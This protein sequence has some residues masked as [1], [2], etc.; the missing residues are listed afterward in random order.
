MKNT[1][2]LLSL[3]LVSGVGFA[4]SR[5]NSPKMTI[6]P[7]PISTLDENVT[8][9]S[10]S[11]D[12]KWIP[13]EYRIYQRIL[14][15]QME[16]LE[17]DPQQLGID[18]FETISTY[19]LY[20]GDDTLLLI[21]K[22]FLDGE[23]D[24]PRSKRGWDDWWSVHYFVIDKPADHH[25]DLNDSSLHEV[26]Y[27]LRASGTIQDVSRRKILQKIE[28][29]INLETSTNRYL[30]LQTQFYSESNTARFMLY[31]NHSIFHDVRGI[32]EDLA[33]RG[34]S[35]F[36]TPRLLD[37]VYFECDLNRFLELGIL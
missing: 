18:N 20:Y 2:L 17:D 32:V 3:T 25:V 14:S 4:Q 31:S 37:Y 29:R 19:P 36:G 1:I 24:Y 28:E 30:I 35:L 6:D 26:E 33:V 11:L 15:S 7:T 12:G 34:H 21:T 8:G 23:Y 10:Y 5:R 16:T 27:R 9:W 22:L 13:G